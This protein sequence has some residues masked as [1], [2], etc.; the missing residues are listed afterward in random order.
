MDETDASELPSDASARRALRVYGAVLGLLAL[1]FTL[2]VLGQ[3]LVAFFHVTFLPPMREWFSGLIPYPV[4]LPIQGVIVVLLFKGAA[5]CARG[6]GF[7]A[8]PRIKIGRFLRG[9]SYLYFA[10]MVLRYIVT[11]ALYPDRR[12]FGGAIPI[13]F[14]WVLAGYLFVLGYFH[15]RAPRS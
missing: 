3:A 11:M 12:W 14:H 5:D 13:F 9:L 10:A 4:L 7:F 1:L 15:T 8:R 6:R 2:R